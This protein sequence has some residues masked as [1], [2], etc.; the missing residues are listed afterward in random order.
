M[1]NVLIKLSMVAVLM[2]L[3]GVIAFWWS[4]NW[5]TGAGI[6]GR[7]D[8]SSFLACVYALW[9]VMVLMGTLF[10]M[11]IANLWDVHVAWVEWRSAWRPGELPA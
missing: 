6:S 7:D 2:L 3:A 9:I 8:L 4:V 5:F 1:K 11:F 10:H